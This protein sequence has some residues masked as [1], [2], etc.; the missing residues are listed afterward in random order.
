MFRN[1]LQQIAEFIGV[2]KQTLCFHVRAMNRVRRAKRREIDPHAFWSDLLR[3][4]GS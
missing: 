2:A 1:I 4:C 3:S